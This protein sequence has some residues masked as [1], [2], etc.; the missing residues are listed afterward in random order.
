MGKMALGSAGMGL[1]VLA[2]ACLGSPEVH[3]PSLPEPELGQMLMLGFRGTTLRADNPILE[4]LRERRIGGVILYERDLPARASNRNITG[5]GQLKGL[6]DQLRAASRSQAPLWVAID[7]E[8]GRVARL[9][10]KDGFPAPGPSAQDL[11]TLDDEALTVAA[12]RRTAATLQAAGVNVNFAPVVDL[13]LNRRSP[14]I[15][16]LERSF[17]AD[18]SLVSRHAALTMETLRSGG[19]LGCLKHFPGHGSAQ[20]DSHLGFTDV[21]HTWREIELE[22]YRELLRSGHCPMVMSAHVFNRSLDPDYPATLSKAT[23][24]GLLRRR[25]GFAGVV[26]TDDLGM[27]AITTRFDLETTIEKSV[28]AGADVLLFGNNNPAGFD[29]DLGRKVHQALARL[30]KDGRISRGRIQASL[31]RIRRLKENGRPP[32]SRSGNPVQATRAAAL[33]SRKCAKDGPPD[34]LPSGH[35]ESRP[36]HTPR[37]LT[38]PA[39]RPSALCRPR[40][41]AA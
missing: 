6:T 25:L 31:E 11:G 7:Q 37:A 40:K 38:A 39:S 34:Q 13:N 4:D 19:V 2:A 22:P 18:P 15:G 28:N 16:A 26:V 5:P 17:G 41:L 29:P 35:E 27:G 36:C 33:S 23:L 20:A 3:R 14:A 32:G 24:E 10:E 30:V 12:A 8:G 21:T 9:R 1:V